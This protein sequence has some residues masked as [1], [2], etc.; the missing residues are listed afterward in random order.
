M[1]SWMTSAALLIH[2]LALAQP[3]AQYAEFPPKS[4]KQVVLV[5]SVRDGDTVKAFFLVP[6][7]I[8]LYGINAPE[9]DTDQG[10]VARD[11]L[12]AMVPAGS[13]TE[14][15]LIGHDKYGRTLA[16]IRTR[17]GGDASAW[18]VAAGHAKEWDGKGPKP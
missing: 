4:G 6:A 10:K 11:A 9:I 7:S 13:R 3:P 17:D 12:A 14:I 18:M 8:R 5:D 2:V 16:K 15:E 1:R